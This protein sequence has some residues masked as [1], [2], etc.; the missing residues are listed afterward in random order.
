MHSES[1]LPLSLIICPLKIILAFFRVKFLGV[2][3]K[4]AREGRGR[5]KNFEIASVVATG[6][7]ATFIVS[8][9]DLL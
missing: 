6:F 8:L 9:H 4:K 5:M 1:F 3:G 2:L 7:S